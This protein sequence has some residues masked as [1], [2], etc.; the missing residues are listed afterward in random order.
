[1]E[2]DSNRTLRLA[3]RQVRSLG[4]ILRDVEDPRHPSWV[5]RPLPEVVNSLLLGA[6]AN[7]ETLRDVEELTHGLG[8]W[9]RSVVTT[10]VSDTTVDSNVIPATREGADLTGSGV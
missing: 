5:E 9:A 8:P 4:P 1:M 6:L 2:L 3:A 10:P 7:C